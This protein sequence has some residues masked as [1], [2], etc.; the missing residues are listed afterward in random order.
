MFLVPKYATTY[1]THPLVAA[2]PALDAHITSIIDINIDFNYVRKTLEHLDSVCATA[3]HVAFFWP[4]IRVLADR[5]MKLNEQY[6]SRLV[7]AIAVNT[8]KSLPP[9]NPAIRAACKETAEIIT[10][11]Q[12]LGRSDEKWNTGYGMSI[13]RTTNYTRETPLGLIHA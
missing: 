1:D 2:S 3:A 6:G 13:M 5:A 7:D 11:A 10:A 8:K 4:S 12:I 9:L